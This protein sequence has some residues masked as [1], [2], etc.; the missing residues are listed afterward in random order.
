MLMPASFQVFLS[1]IM[2]SSTSVCVCV[3][4]LNRLG[5]GSAVCAVG[6]S[7]ALSFL[8]DIGEACRQLWHEGGRAPG[9]T[10]NHSGW[11]DGQTD[12]AIDRLIE[13]QASTPT[14]THTRSE[15]KQYITAIQVNLRL[16]ICSRLQ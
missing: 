14:C 10:P 9:S 1:V 15:V 4:A 3:C 12:D 7:L 5:L 11:T 13:A 2:Q 8:A 6:I 16:L